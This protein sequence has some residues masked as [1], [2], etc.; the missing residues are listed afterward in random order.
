MEHKNQQHP[1]YSKDADVYLESGED[2]FS[3]L[4]KVIDK[5]GFFAN[6]DGVFE[7]SGKNKEE[8]L[9]AVK[10]NIMTASVH[11]DP[12]PIYT[13]PELVEYLIDR[14]REKG[15]ANIAV[16]EARN[17]YDYSYQ[18]RTVQAVAD[19]CGYTVKNYRIEDLSEQKEPFDYG[20]VLGPHTVGRTWRDADYRISF[21]KNKTHW[22]S[23]YTG[24]LKNVYGCLPAWDKMKDYHGKGRE[25][26]QCTILSAHHFPVHFGFLDAWV[27]GDGFSGYIRDADPNHTKTIFAG[28][29]ILCLDWVMGE[30][31][32]LDPAKNPVI[33][34]GT[35][36]W[37]TPKSTPIG[38]MTPYSNWKNVSA[39]SIAAI[40]K[41]E[42]LYWISRFSSRCLACYMDKRF[43][44]V[45]KGQWFFGTVQAIS[46]FLGCIF[47]SKQRK[48]R[49]ALKR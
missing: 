44:P 17:V 21:A 27:S 5:S 13:D 8:F 25:F 12:S 43:P 40:D 3:A 29:N 24:C 31:M 15:Y 30:K 49:K 48:K 7:K 47:S 16:V 35:Q 34:E 37:G 36:L 23:Y 9:I 19:M 18:D 28:E 42:E 41:M 46:R 1:V 33:R 11:E 32:G 26:Y 10:P 38:D 45:K 20:G 4:Q 39:F 6:V 22:Q 2:K 14:L